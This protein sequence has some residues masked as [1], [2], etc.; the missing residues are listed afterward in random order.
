MSDT[1][2]ANIVFV[3]YKSGS[4]SASEE[5]ISIQV[6]LARSVRVLLLPP[7]VN[8]GSLDDNLDPQGAGWNSGLNLFDPFHTKI[9]LQ[10]GLQQ[11]DDKGP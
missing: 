2:A 4:V 8:F 7:P 3:M 5:W 1:E 6:L 9:A 11:Q 10:L